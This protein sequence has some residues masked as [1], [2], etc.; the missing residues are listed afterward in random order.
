MNF[1]SFRWWSSC[2]WKFHSNI[3][4]SNGDHHGYHQ[5][6]LFPSLFLSSLSCPY[7]F[8]SISEQIE[9]FSELFVIPVFQ[10][11]HLKKKMIESKWRCTYE[12]WEDDKTHDTWKRKG[13]LFL[14]HEIRPKILVIS[15]NF[16]FQFF[17]NVDIKPTCEYIWHYE[18]HKKP[19]GKCSVQSNANILNY[20]FV[21]TFTMTNVKHYEERKT[22][23]MK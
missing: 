14:R 5:H 19:Q 18:L 4:D 1:T 22:Y 15:L 20:I 21:F 3:S 6:H 11:L 10:S 17:V 9:Y 8:A 2:W 7:Y 16:S 13:K 23:N 12:W